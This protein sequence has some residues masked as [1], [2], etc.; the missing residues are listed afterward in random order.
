MLN[1]FH[2][3]PERYGRTDRQTDG[4]TDRYAIS[5]SHIS[6]LRCSRAIKTTTT[7]VVGGDNANELTFT[8]LGTFV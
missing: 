6:I 8:Y 2:L 1:R 7:V 4:Q 3:I 5:I